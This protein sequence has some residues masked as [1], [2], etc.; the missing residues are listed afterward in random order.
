MTGKW[1][2]DVLLVASAID[3]YRDGGKTGDQGNTR[4]QHA[5]IKLCSSL[6]LHSKCPA[7]G[8]FFP[9]LYLDTAKYTMTRNPIQK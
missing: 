2:C 1:G 4:S 8:S 7:L 9:A 6:R 3:I 5:R